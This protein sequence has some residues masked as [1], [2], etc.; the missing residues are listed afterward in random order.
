ME[1]FF[2]KRIK[3]ALEVWQIGLLSIVAL[4]GLIG[5][6]AMVE[7]AATSNSPRGLPK[8][9]YDLARIPAETKHVI[10]WVATDYRPTLAS[11]QRFA[12][13]FGFKRLKPG[14]DETLL[15]A[16]TDGDKNRSVVEIVDLN[17]GGVLHRYE[18]DIDSLNALSAKEPPLQNLATEKAEPLYTMVHPILTD[19][20]GL[21]FHGAS[22]PLM[23]IDVC[24]KVEWIVD[25]VFHHS[26]ERD[27]EGNYWATALFYPP[28]VA[29]L[30][31]DGADHTI[32]KV[33]PDGKVLFEKSIA[34]LLL[35]NGMRHFVFNSSDTPDDPVHVNDVQP[36]LTD[37]TYWRR[38]DLFLSV[39]N[40]SLIVLY[41]PSTN[42]VIWHKAGPWLRQ[43]DVD[44]LN[45]HQISIFDNN[46]AI[47][48]WGGTVLG[49]NDTMIYDFATD[50]VT[51]PY[52][53]GYEAHDIRT[54][55][56]G[57]SEILPDGEIFVEEQN[58]GRLLKMNQA[59][60]ITW[61]YINRAEE[62]GR[63]YIVD[64]ARY[65]KRSRAQEA[66]A[67]AAENCD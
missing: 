34:E 55:T 16:R 4:F 57:R 46:A 40:S 27:S 18:P 11:D 48:P 13:E 2:L 23:K 5:F 32:V 52:S 65:L 49:V 9:A 61:Q 20:G 12:G 28:K 21:I 6:G 22:S 17:D 63:V 31:R 38:G 66:V 44:I 14:Q 50:A 51:T 54:F 59:G 10:N 60:E 19:D 26:I 24:S 15:L 3:F 53:S 42:K 39:R 36:A 56:E 8:L 29:R 1:K 45:D 7:M 30:G 43:H 37:G 41:R 35:E 64:W 67:L 33:S 47:M 25:K 62:D 58:Y